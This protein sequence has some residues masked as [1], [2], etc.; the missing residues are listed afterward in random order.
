[1]KASRF[2]FCTLFVAASLR[3]TPAQ[4]AEAIRALQTQFKSLRQQL[5]AAEGTDER[6]ALQKKITAFIEEA[7]RNASEDLRPVVLLLLKVTIPLQERSA[8]YSQLTERFHQSGHGDP[9]TLKR[10]S[11]IAE[12]IR[13]LE[14]LERKNDDFIQA[15]ETI[16]ERMEKALIDGGIPADLRA[17]VLAGHRKGASRGI[18]GMLATRELDAETFKL[19]K[20]LYRHLDEHWGKWRVENDDFKWTDAVAQEKNDDI[21]VKLQNVIERANTSQPQ[22]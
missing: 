5:A 6:V 22:N 19:T 21:L 17:A 2:L 4:D 8:E 7:A 12:R 10:R 3:G 13:E 9:A 20:E 11:E 14:L 1:M 18:P 15:L 16:N